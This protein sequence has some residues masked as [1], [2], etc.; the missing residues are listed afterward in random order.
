VAP[1]RQP[2]VAALLP[3]H[4]GPVMLKQSEPVSWIEDCRSRSRRAPRCPRFIPAAHVLIISEGSIL[5]L[6]LVLELQGRVSGSA[7]P[8]LPTGLAAV[9]RRKR[10]TR[11]ATTGMGQRDV[12]RCVLGT[13][14]PRT[15][16]DKY[17][18]PLILSC[19]C[20]S[21]FRHT[22]LAPAPPPAASTPTQLLVLVRR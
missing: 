8:F 19:R 13:A 10:L 1:S 2:S 20:R 22:R 4:K 3:H 16:Q 11:N 15:E 12:C 18:G 6:S 14:W 17:A 7:S 21:V 9:T 5:V